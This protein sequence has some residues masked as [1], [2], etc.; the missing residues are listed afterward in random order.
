MLCKGDVVIL[1][2]SGSNNKRRKAKVEY[3]NDYE[4]IPLVRVLFFLPYWWPP[5][6]CWRLEDEGKTWRRAP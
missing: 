2:R 5:G 1:E 3:A 4:F 6:G